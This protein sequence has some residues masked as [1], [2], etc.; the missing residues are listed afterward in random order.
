MAGRIEA[1]LL[2]GDR[3]SALSSDVTALRNKA[4]SLSIR[5]SCVLLAGLRTLGDTDAAGPIAK[6][7]EEAHYRRSP[8]VTL[9]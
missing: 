3:S 5:E 6:R 4:V 2:A 7:I 8:C 1:R 9:R